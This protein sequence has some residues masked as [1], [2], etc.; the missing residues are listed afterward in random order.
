M[1]IKISIMNQKGGVGKSTLVNILADNLRYIGRVLILDLDQQ[2]NQRTLLGVKDK[3]E[4]E[5]SAAGILLHGYR[6]E[7]AIIPATSNVDLISSGSKAIEGVDRSC[8]NQ[9]ESELL[10]KKRFAS[11]EDKYDYIL[12][13]SN[14]TMNLIHAN[15]TCYADYIIIPCDMEMLSFAA[16]RSIIYFIES[17]SSKIKYPTA[18]ILGIVPI[19]FDPRRN[20]DDMILEDLKVLEENDML[21]GGV[22]FPSLRESSNMKTTQSRKKFLSDTFPKGKLTED[23]KALAESIIARINETGA[24]N[25]HQESILQTQQSLTTQI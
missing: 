12:I 1:A 5:H 15:I 16:T 10:L 19:R 9:D 20:V 24:K 8:K 7:T 6:P 4:K 18:K 23:C 21:S 2:N 14:P 25:S 17:F 11:L 3:S 22:I 13:D